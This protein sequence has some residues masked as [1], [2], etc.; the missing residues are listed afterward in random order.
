MSVLDRDLEG[1]MPKSFDLVVIGPGTAYLARAVGEKKA[2]E[3][4]CLCR[5]YSAALA[6]QMGL[7]NAI[8]SR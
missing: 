2:R 6:L 3:I 1:T 5:R 7:V 8:G 4:W